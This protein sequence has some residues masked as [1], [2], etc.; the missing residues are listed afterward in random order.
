MSSSSCT[1][2]YVVFVHC[3]DNLAWN[4]QQIKVVVWKMALKFYL[5]KKI[6]CI[7]E[8]VHTISVSKYVLPI[9]CSIAFISKAKMTCFPWVAFCVIICRKIIVTL[10]A[11]REST[12]FYSNLIW[13]VVGWHKINSEYTLLVRLLLPYVSKVSAQGVL[14]YGHFLSSKL[15]TCLERNCVLNLQETW[16][17]H[18]FALEQFLLLLLCNWYHHL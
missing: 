11:K 8:V 15:D 12:C 1:K 13:K 18:C 5:P 17:L 10:D 9:I 3:M 7:G 2:L 4:R 6:P 16:N 14:P